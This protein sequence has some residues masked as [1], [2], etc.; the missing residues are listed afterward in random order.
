MPASNAR[1][2]NTAAAG[3]LVRTAAANRGGQHT[4]LPHGA[5]SLTIRNVQAHTAAFAIEL[6]AEPEVD[7]WDSR[8][9]ASA[10]PPEPE[11]DYWQ[12]GR[13]SPGRPESGLPR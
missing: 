7:Y 12:D 3:T 4:P 5:A 11:I 8:S 6:V 1:G 2:S 10:A 13:T 9:A